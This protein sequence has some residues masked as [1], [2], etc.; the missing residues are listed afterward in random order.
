MKNKQKIIGSMVIGVIFLVFLIVGYFISKPSRINS[1]EVFVESVSSNGE[2]I[3][4]KESKNIVVEIKGEVKKPG[5]YSLKPSSRVEDLIKS[6]GGFTED[7]DTF[8]ISLAKKLRDEDCIVVNKKGNDL[9]INKGI[10]IQST[11]DK[12]N[13]N[14]ASKE[15]LDTIPGIGPVTAQKI[16][17]YREKNGDFSSIED[18]KKIGGIGDKTLDKFKDKIDIR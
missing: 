5:V 9:N 8:R 18:L 10:N 3:E 13:I 12:I 4:N 15:Q 7:A 6:A 16:L 17:D 11:S 2:N 1:D 14:T